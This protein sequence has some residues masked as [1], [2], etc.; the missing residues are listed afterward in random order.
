MLTT[1]SMSLP[2]N[3]L[4]YV[5]SS[6]SNSEGLLNS[7]IPLSR[8]V[9]SALMGPVFIGAVCVVA[10]DVARP[11]SQIFTFVYTP[12]RG[13]PYVLKRWAVFAESSNTAVTNLE[14]CQYY[15]LDAFAVG[16]IRFASCFSLYHQSV[17]IPGMFLSYLAN[18]PLQFIRIERVSVASSR[19]CFGKAGRIKDFFG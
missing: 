14:Q 7:P 19:F 15:V 1:Q 17:F 2:L 13:L 12:F 5:T 9:A 3:A 6:S 18:C 8:K 10:A 11:A 4:I 16:S